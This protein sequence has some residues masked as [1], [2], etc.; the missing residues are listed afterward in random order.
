MHRRALVLFTL[1]LLS[2]LALGAC[3][4]N[5]SPTL[6][7]PK[8]IITKAIEAIQKAKYVHI[9]AT[10]DGTL[11]STVLGGSQAGD[12][13]L[14]GTT[15]AADVDFGNKNL[16]MSAGVPAML[17]L[18]ADIIVLGPDTYTKI[19]LS[20]P[21]YAKST[22]ATSTPADPATAITQVKDFLDRPEIGPAKKDDVSCGSKSCYVVA[23]DLTAAEL[24]TLA[25][26][27]DLGDA[28]ITASMD[29]DKDT[30][31]PASL[32][33]TAKGSTV[34]DLTLKITFTNWDKAVTITAPP[35][36]QVQ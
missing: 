34:G 28:T 4:G 7:D 36:D 29:V 18:T 22:T 5:K 23:F 35:A 24:K 8:E 3:G 27:T 2:T 33:L 12:I 26:D 31:Y 17:G 25:P 15:M 11:Q 13:T 9:E 1:V 10:V 14:A 19:S 30:L 32:N 21:K 20:G 16:H 6:S